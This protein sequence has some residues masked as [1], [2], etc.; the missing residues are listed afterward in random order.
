M[1]LSTYYSFI[2]QTDPDLA[3]PE[4]ED[5]CN[6]ADE[7][8]TDKKYNYGINSLKWAMFQISPID[9]KRIKHVFK[10]ILIEHKARNKSI[11]DLQFQIMRYSAVAEYRLK[12]K[13]NTNKRID[14]ATIDHFAAADFNIVV[15]ETGLNLTARIFKETNADAILFTEPE[16][17][18]AGLQIRVN[19]KLN[20]RE[21]FKQYF[22][23]QVSEIE[24]GWTFV[25]DTQHLIINHGSANHTPSAITIETFKTIICNYFK[26]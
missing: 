4:I 18:K 12:I 9:P 5:Y 24:A 3:N 19:S 6:I 2:Q 22:F 1:N 13:E 20:L 15:N 11:N 7:I 16:L 14:L 17:Q 21:G 10:S 8:Q 26:D 25:G 23:D